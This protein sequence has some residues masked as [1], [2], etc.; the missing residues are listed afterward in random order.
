MLFPSLHVDVSIGNSP[1]AQTS[2]AS[3]GK[4]LGKILGN[5]RSEC[6]TNAK[7]CHFLT[8]VSPKFSRVSNGNIGSCAVSEASKPV[9]ADGLSSS[10]RNT[11]M[12]RP[13]IAWSVNTYW[14]SLIQKNCRERLKIGTNFGATLALTVTSA[15]AS[16]GGKRYFWYLR[17]SGGGE[18]VLT[19]IFSFRDLDC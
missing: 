8:S 4:Y 13:D 18:G 3:R 10:W 19:W 6:V 9:W 12:V 14:H 16:F 11:Q 2:H 1:E 15:G 17:R 5:R 7:I